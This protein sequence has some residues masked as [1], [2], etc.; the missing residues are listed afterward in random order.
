MEDNPSDAINEAY[1]NAGYVLKFYRDIFNWDSIDG[2]NMDVI[3]TVHY[4]N[5]YQNACKF[6]CVQLSCTLFV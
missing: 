6:A 5:G 1:D 3:S 2:K 4:D